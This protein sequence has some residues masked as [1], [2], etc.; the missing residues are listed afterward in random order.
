MATAPQA[1]KKAIRL[2]APKKNVVR[3]GASGSLTRVDY[4]GPVRL[5]G[6]IC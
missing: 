2:G 4:A 5:G 6:F 1:R 3:G